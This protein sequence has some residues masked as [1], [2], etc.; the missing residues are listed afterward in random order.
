MLGASGVGLSY[1]GPTIY[2]VTDTNTKDIFRVARSLMKDKEG[3]IY[4]H[5]KLRTLEPL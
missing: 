3:E 5:L 1:F 2:A 4:F